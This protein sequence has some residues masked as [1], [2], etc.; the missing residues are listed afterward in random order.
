MLYRYATSADGAL[1][2]KAKIYTP[3]EHEISRKDIDPDALKVIRGLV[4]K[5]FKAY[6][7]GGAIR[8]LLLGRHPKDF[9]V[10]TDARPKQIR[11]VFSHAR[12][13]GRRFRLVHVYCSPD[14]YVEVSTFRAGSNP[15]AGENIYGTLGEDAFRRDFTMNALFYCPL[16]E[17]V[18]DYVG[19]VQDIRRR[20][21]RSL[22]APE[23]SFREDPVRMLR[24]VKYAAALELK[25]PVAVRM[26]IGRLRELIRSCSKERLTEEI[27]KILQS[28]HAAAI[29]LAASRLRL[30]DVLMPFLQEGGAPLRRVGR[31]DR[32][33]LRLERLDRGVHRGKSTSRGEMLAVLLADVKSG[34][35]RWLSGAT[36]GLVVELRRLMMP[37]CPSNGD[38][39]GALRFLRK[40]QQAE[41]ASADARAKA[42][43]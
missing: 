14:R 28:G 34:D 15:S 26:A 39:R 42:E 23:R 3:Q 2:L 30:L 31:S 13:I 8:D 19:G 1:K 25:L 40:W 21:V 29:L 4:K 35:P 11:R 38:M 5:G 18:I 43:A 41:A 27:F 17:Y 20:R 36:A 24:A 37:L 16:R 9:D 7:V 12:I 32:F 22:T 33:Y 6:V 10:A